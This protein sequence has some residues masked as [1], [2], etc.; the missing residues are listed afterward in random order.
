MYAINVARRLIRGLVRQYAVWLNEVTHGKLRPD[1]VTIAGFLLHFVVAYFIAV[2]DFIPAAI[3]LVVFGLL[4]TL[5]GE[6]ARMQGR[7]SVH[8]MLLDAITDRLK[9][10]I[11]YAGAAVTLVGSHPTAAA[12]CVIACGVSL[13]VSYIK[14]KGEAVLA[15]KVHIS[16]HRLNYIFQDGLMAFEVRMFILV[17]GLLINQLLAAVIIIAVGGLLTLTTRFRRITRELQKQPE[18]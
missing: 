2:D 11:L 10:V 17:V 12:W 15:A 16:H 14:A 9:E 13:C 7:D 6:L 8:G 5:D 4:D 3:L 1:D 18:S